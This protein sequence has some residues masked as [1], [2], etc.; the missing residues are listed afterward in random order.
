[1]RENN[2]KYVPRVV[3][4]HNFVGAGQSALL[5][6]PQGGEYAGQKTTVGSV[7]F[8]IKKDYNYNEAWYRIW[9]IPQKGVVLDHVDII[10][11]SIDYPE[12]NKSPQK[13]KHPLEII[14]AQRPGLES[15]PIIFVF[16]KCD[17][18]DNLE[19]CKKCASELQ[20]TDYFACSSKTGRNILELRTKIQTAVN[21][22]VK[23]RKHEA[24]MKKEKDIQTHW[25]TKRAISKPFWSSSQPKLEVTISDSTDHTDSDIF[26]L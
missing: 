4:L 26:I 24:E 8:N 13:T 12:L 5:N 3:M 14:K 18:D 22:I 10:L 2:Q 17:S 1:M 6:A 16:T 19:T 21:N 15:L 7:F 25:S 23:R 20:I 9:D 11:Y